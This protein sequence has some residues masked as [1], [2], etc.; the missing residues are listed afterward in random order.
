LLAVGLFAKLFLAPGLAGSSG[1]IFAVIA[2]AL[3]LMP[4]TVIDVAY[5][6]CFP[7]SVVIC[8]FQRQKPKYELNWILTWGIVSVPAL[9]CLVI[10][11]VLELW[12][13]VWRAATYDWVWSWTPTAH[14]LGMLCGVVLVLLLP[15]RISMPRSSQAEIS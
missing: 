5:L 10:I 1:A 2:M 9:W 12:S 7:L 15:K 3:I 14:L 6:A 13:L 8:L 11:P 4:K